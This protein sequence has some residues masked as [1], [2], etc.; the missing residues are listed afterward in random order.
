MLYSPPTEAHRSNTMTWS[1]YPVLMGKRAHSHPSTSLTFQDQQSSAYQPLLTSIC[2]SST[3]LYGH[4]IPTPAV[5]H[6]HKE[7][8]QEQTKE[9]TPITD[10]QDIITQYHECFSGIGMFQREYHITLDPNIPPVIHPPRRMPISLKDDIKNELEDMVK[11]GI[12]TK[13][14]EG[15][16][17][18]RVNSLV[19]RRK[20]NGRLRLCLD[21]KDLNAAIQ[22]EHHVTPTLEEILPK[23]TGTTV[24]STVDAKC[25]YWNVVLDK[26]SS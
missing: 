20:Q 24:F 19:Y 21:P 18:P 13:I 17:T 5:M 11:N 7:K 22:R 8:T 12:I 2:Y 6:I 1:L 14:E 15:E 4:S 23:L 10:K 26:E 9:T 25:G 16:S 3:V